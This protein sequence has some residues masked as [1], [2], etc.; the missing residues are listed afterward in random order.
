M[1]YSGFVLTKCKA[2]NFNCRLNIPCIQ[3]S[4]NLFPLKKYAKYSCMALDD[5]IFD[6]QSVSI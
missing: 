1:I 4:Y 3:H 6:L 5:V 2:A